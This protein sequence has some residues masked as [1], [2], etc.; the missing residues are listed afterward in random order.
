M[1]ENGIDTSEIWLEQ[2]GSMQP[3]IVENSKYRASGYINNYIKAI[4]YMR[5]EQDFWDYLLENDLA[6]EK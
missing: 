4:R 5:D 3:I 6:V 1:K 2:D